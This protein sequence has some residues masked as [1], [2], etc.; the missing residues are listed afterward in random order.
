MGHAAVVHNV[1]LHASRVKS[2]HCLYFTYYIS[3]AVG[4]NLQPL[5]NWIKKIINFLSTASATKMSILSFPIFQL[6]KNR[7]I[8][9]RGGTHQYYWYA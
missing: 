4:E 6:V 9:D 3:E 5:P 1:T 2:P 7:Q 8:R